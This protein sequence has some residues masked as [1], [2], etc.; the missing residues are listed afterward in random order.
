[1]TLKGFLEACPNPSTE[2]SK[3][4]VENMIILLGMKGMSEPLGYT[5]F[6]EHEF[7]K[8]LKSKEKEVP[9]AMMALWTRIV[10][11]NDHF[12]MSIDAA[13][14]LSTFIRSFGDSTLYMSYIMLKSHQ[15]G[16]SNITLNFL[17]E[18]IFPW[19]MFNEQQLAMM[20]ELQK[21]SGSPNANL[22]D[23]GSAWREYLF[24]EGAGD[25]VVVRFAEGDDR[26]LTIEE[27]DKCGAVKEPSEIEGR[28]FFWL[29]NLYV[30]TSK[31]DY[32]KITD[33]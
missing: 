15:M 23:D 31:D 14:F 27:F 22:L 5:E 26:P 25:K 13:L 20:W 24:G 9:R 19:G 6:L 17:A 8:R 3:E 4:D 1:M 21:E 29:G 16:V 2:L 28:M 10:R 32:Q 33:R 18:R 11:V 30:S 12:K 7:T